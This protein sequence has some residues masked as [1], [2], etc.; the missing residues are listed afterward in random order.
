MKDQG[1]AIGPSSK[2]QEKGTALGM[3]RRIRLLDSRKNYLCD[4]FD[5]SDQFGHS[6]KVNCSLDTEIDDERK[7]E[8][9]MLYGMKHGKLHI[10]IFTHRMKLKLISEV[11]LQ[12]VE[13]GLL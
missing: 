12:K 8:D 1:R 5:S 4:G 2:I 9:V 13:L 10:I 11:N 3:L 7:R 6:S